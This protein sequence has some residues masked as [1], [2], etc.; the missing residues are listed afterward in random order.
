MIVIF[1]IFGLIIGSFLNVVVYRL[2]TAESLLGRSHCPQ[3]KK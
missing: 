3:C 2:R 1:L